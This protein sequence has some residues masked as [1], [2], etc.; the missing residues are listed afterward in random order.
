MPFSG[1]DEHRR[2]RQCTQGALTDA[3]VHPTIARATLCQTSLPLGPAATCGSTPTTQ[4]VEEPQAKD[5]LF[6]AQA[7]AQD[8]PSQA[9]DQP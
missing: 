9:Q 3:H 6:E 1:D 2:R 4:A 5:L 7:Q 8:Q